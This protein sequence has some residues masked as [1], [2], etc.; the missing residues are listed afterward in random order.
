MMA[1]VAITSAVFLSGTGTEVSAQQ[2]GTPNDPCS[3]IQPSPVPDQVAGSQQV[4]EQQQQVDPCDPPPP[5]VK[6]CHQF[7][8][9]EWAIVEVEVSQ[10]PQALAS[11]DQYPPCPADPDAHSHADEDGHFRDHTYSCAEQTTATP[12]P[13]KTPTATLTSTPTGGTVTVTPTRTAT[14][15]ATAVA[16]VGS[17]VTPVPPK[18]GNAGM[19][20]G[21]D[22]TRNGVVAG[23]GLAVVLGAAGAFELRKRRQ[24]S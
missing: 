22:G 8:N 3:D 6:L 2:S 17:T 23:L 13:T 20:G 24:Q 9:G 16:T 10:I 18:T 11:G 21:D 19:L 5:T 14:A 15:T 1:L 4:I 12:T 7:T